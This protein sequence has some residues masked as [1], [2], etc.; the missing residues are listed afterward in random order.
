MYVYIYIYNLSNKILSHQ[1][2]NDLCG[3]LKFT[4][5]PLP[6]KIELKNYVQ[7]FSRKLRLLEFF[8]KEKE[9]EEEKSSDDSII[10]NK[11]VFNSPRNRDNILD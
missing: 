8:Y 5:T 6:N 4:P 11:S 10:K 9:S 3:G 1:H 2:V 7:H